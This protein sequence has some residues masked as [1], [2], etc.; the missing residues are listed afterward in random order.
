VSRE[1]SKNVEQ[2]YVIK[3]FTNKS[4]KPVDIQEFG[5]EVLSK[6]QICEWHTA[7]KESHCTV[8]SLPNGYKT[9]EWHGH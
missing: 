1:F 7:S 9:S 3:S 5:D 4:K 2:Q 6:T 8:S